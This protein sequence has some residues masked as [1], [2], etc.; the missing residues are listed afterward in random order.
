MDIFEFFLKYVGKMVGAGAVAEIFDKS[1]P[2]KNRP[3][4]QHCNQVFTD[5]CHF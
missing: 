5:D 2:Q 1:E 3:V 4:A